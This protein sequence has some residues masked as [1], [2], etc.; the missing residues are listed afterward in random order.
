MAVTKE[1]GYM[2][3]PEKALPN[4]CSDLRLPLQTQRLALR[5]LREGDLED[6]FVLCSHPEI[7]R[8]IRPP[9]SREDVVRH[10]RDRLRPWHFEEMKWYSLAVCRIGEERVIGE[11][12]FKLE[13][14]EVRRAEIGY[15]FHPD[16]QGKGYAA[17]ATDALIA[18]LFD[19]LH[20][21]K[22]VAY[23]VPENIPS[24]K[25]LQ[26]FGFQREGTWR[27]HLRLEGAWCDLSTYGLLARERPT[28]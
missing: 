17:E 2:S 8:Y 9:M 13:S 1:I 28:R 23:C 15:R 5:G 26:R 6:V 25:L 7:C 14:L 24:I 21:H 3:V 19:E 10:I 11:M 16:G 27:E 18:W 22:L 12:V 20:L 4:N